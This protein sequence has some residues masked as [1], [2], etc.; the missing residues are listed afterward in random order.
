MLVRHVNKVQATQY[1]G[2]DSRGVAI[3]PLITHFV[4]SGEGTVTGPD[5]PQSLEPGVAVF[6]PGHEAHQF[7]NTGN[8]PLVFTCAVPNQGQG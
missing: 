8:A 4:I 2:E 3:R 5:G 6:I 7:R 1:E